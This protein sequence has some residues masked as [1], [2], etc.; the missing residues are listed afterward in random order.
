MVQ[1]AIALSPVVGVSVV[2]VEQLPTAAP[3]TLQL[4]V[5]VGIFVVPCTVAVKVIEVPTVTD[6]VG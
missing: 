2:G 4:T 6:C 5:P 1:V 3:L